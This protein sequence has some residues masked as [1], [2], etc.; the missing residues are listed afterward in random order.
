MCFVL[1]TDIVI[2]SKPGYRK[3]AGDDASCSE[4]SF[5]KIA[6]VQCNK[7]AKLVSDNNR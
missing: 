4:R 1:L 3:L 5:F 6:T 2:N 7:L